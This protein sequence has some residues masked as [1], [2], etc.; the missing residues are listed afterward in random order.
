MQCKDFV[1]VSFYDA[2]QASFFST[3]DKHSWTEVTCEVIS[4]TDT[5]RASAALKIL[6]P[7]KC[8]GISCECSL[9]HFISKARQSGSLGSGVA[10]L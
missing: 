10:G 1:Q 6:A 2:V 5:P 3:L 4:F 7:S 9:V 8:I